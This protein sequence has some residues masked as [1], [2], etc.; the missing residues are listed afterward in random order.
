MLDTLMSQP[1]SS[2]SSSPTQPPRLPRIQPTSIQCF[3]HSF[4]I[5]SR[6]EAFKDVLER[7]RR[8]RHFG[9]GPSSRAFMDHS[10]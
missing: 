1:S 4:F 6:N 3:D 5:R 7:E 10:V 9:S 8:H 2:F